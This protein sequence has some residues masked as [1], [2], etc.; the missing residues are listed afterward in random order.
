MEELLRGLEAVSLKDEDP[1]SFISDA[2]KKITIDSLKL[3]I[4]GQDYDVGTDSKLVSK[5]IEIYV[6]EMIKNACALKANENVTYEINPCQN[7][8]PD[9]IVSIGNDAYAIDIKTTY[10]IN[11]NK[12]NGFTLGTYQ[13]YFRDRK[14]M[15]NCMMPYE[16][17]K[18]HLCICVI[19]E[20]V[21]SSIVVKH[22]IFI[23]KWKLASRKP[24]SGNTKNIGSITNLRDILQAKAQF[25]DESEFNTFW[26]A[27]PH[28]K[29]MS[30]TSSVTLEDKAY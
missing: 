22:T 8:Y 16:N 9:C 6:C 24:G 23:E 10:L 28:Q 7:S 14:S 13:G 18:S 5:M 11:E 4:N 1:L 15:K 20:R 21:E 25:A 12:V 3:N 2:V 29:A 27:F 26:Q 17:F 19:Y 30:K